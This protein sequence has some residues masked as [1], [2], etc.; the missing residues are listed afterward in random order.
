MRRNHFRLAAALL[1][2]CTAPAVGQA[3]SSGAAFLLMPIGGR[4]AGLGQAAVADGGSNEAVF[5]NPAG[6]ARL[7]HSGIAVNYAQTF[8]SNNTAISAMVASTTEGYGGRYS[9]CPPYA[10]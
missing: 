1:F 5:W 6:L 10:R 3:G 8:V 9:S 2:L 7:D 4:A